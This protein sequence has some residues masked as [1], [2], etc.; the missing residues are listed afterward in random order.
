MIT[1]PELYRLKLKVNYEEF[2]VQMIK[3]SSKP[4]SLC[5]VFDHLA[6][7]QTFSHLTEDTLQSHLFALLY[8]LPQADS[9]LNCFDKLELT[10]KPDENQ[11]ELGIFHESFNNFANIFILAHKDQASPFSNCFRGAKIGVFEFSYK[12]LMESDCDKHVLY[13]SE[14]IRANYAL[15][16]SLHIRNVEDKALSLSMET[17]DKEIEELYHK[18][19]QSTGRIETAKKT[20]KNLASQLETLDPIN[21]FECIKCKVNNRSII[22]LPCGHLPTCRNC[23]LYLL[24]IPVGVNLRPKLL[25]CPYCM[26]RVLEAREVFY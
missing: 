3:V 17:L 7:A 11:Y 18:N 16:K 10:L 9:S 15:A 5:L 12:Q 20:I 14:L 23:T 24:K 8:E 13:L 4:K 19:I 2:E 25:K 26:E 22:F 1:L 21:K 6:R